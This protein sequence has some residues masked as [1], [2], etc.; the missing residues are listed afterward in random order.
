MPQEFPDN[1]L[2]GFAAAAAVVSMVELD[3]RR[4][5][6]GRLVLSHDPDLAGH[7]VS[8]STWRELRELDLGHGHRPA[9][10]EQVIEALPGL[11]L[12]VEIKNDPR[13][14]GF[15]PDHRTALEAATMLRNSDILTSFFWPTVD[16]VRVAHPE[17]RTG[18][19]VDR[20]G[21]LHDAIS[22]AAEQGHEVVAP[23]HSLV[24]PDVVN[25]SLAAGVAM[26]T[27]TV[28][29]PADAV[30]FASWGVSTIITDDPR[31][32]SAAVEGR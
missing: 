31:T 3:V 1:T 8:A 13:Q 20:G 10:L 7:V 21:P 15:E 28:N 30:A 17:A 12:D 2:A 27:W 32:I 24:T 16:A 19:L 11:A 5:L 25:E 9:L 22:H 29:D 26:A 18:L 6:D 23:H 4:S 14:P